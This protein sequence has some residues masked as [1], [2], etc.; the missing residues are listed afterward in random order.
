MFGEL[1]GH[2][3]LGSDGFAN[4]KSNATGITQAGGLAT[5]SVGAASFLNTAPAI[6]NDL[7]NLW[8]VVEG[9]PTEYANSGAGMLA[10]RFF[11]GD[12][13][14]KAVADTFGLGLAAFSGRVPVSS[15]WFD[16]G[17]ALAQY[18]PA[19]VNKTFD[20]WADASGNGNPGKSTAS[21]TADFFGGAD[22]TSK[23]MD[24]GGAALGSYNFTPSAPFAGIGPQQSFGGSGYTPL[25]GSGA[26]NFSSLG[27][28]QSGA[29]TGYGPFM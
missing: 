20:F 8:N 5:F 6:P 27:F 17:S 21:W 16:T 18:R 4:I 1:T 3:T 7:V 26:S 22:A 19:N 12:I 9:T 28:D 24:W 13:G 25:G 14:A 15:Q 11:P 29:F 10:D 2:Q 23:A